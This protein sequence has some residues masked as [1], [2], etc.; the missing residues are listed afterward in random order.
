MQSKLFFNYCVQARS[1][2]THSLC[3]PVLDHRP[4]SNHAGPSK[5]A[6]DDHGGGVVFYRAGVSYHACSPV[7]SRES[8]KKTS[9]VSV[10]RRAHQANCELA[11]RAC[12]APPVFLCARLRFGYVRQACLST[13][14]NAEAIL[15]ALE[16]GYSTAHHNRNLSCSAVSHEQSTAVRSSTFAFECRPLHRRQA[17]CRKSYIS[18]N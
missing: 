11:H 18:H 10:N 3:S 9:S 16:C 7:R 13:A 17:V 14:V 8:A 12:A 6:V 4:A 5:A 2:S 1:R 15:A